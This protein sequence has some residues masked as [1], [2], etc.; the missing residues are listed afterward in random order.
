MSTVYHHLL[1]CT[2]SVVVSTAQCTVCKV[3]K[4]VGTP[5]L[6]NMRACLSITVCLST[7][8]YYLKR[9]RD[10]GC[11]CRFRPS[12]LPCEQ[13]YTQLV[14]VVFGIVPPLYFFSFLMFLLPFMLCCG[15]AN[16]M[17][18]HTVVLVSSEIVDLAIVLV[19]FYTNQCQ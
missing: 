19:V 5:K 2:D 16:V 15:F 11:V 14:G 7:Y 1:D 12:S 18:M 3:H 9:C 4:H 8:Y 17:P 13:S 6:C 10:G